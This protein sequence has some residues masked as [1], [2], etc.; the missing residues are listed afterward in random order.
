MPNFTRSLLTSTALTNVGLVSAGLIMMSGAAQ[1]LPQN[2]TVAG[3]SATISTSGNTTTINQS[4]SRAVIDWQ[5]FS[6]ASGETTNFVQPSSSSVA[7]NRVTGVNPS[8][9][10]GSL[11]ANGQV[12]LVNPNGILFNQGAQ[13]NV[14]GL[15]AS[16]ANISTANAMAGNMVFDQ[17]SASGTA[18]IVNKGTITAA[19]GGLVALV[20]PG[21]QNS[22]IITANLGK[23]SL[24]SGDQWT[25]D[26]YGDRLV[27]FT[28]NGQ[29]AA[30]ITGAKTD[31][32]G[33]P[34]VGVVQDKNGSI[35]ASA[36][37]VQITANVARQV[38]SNAI[39]MD[40]IVEASSV[41]TQG[42]AIV[43][44]AGDGNASITGTMNANGTQGGTI[45]VAA[46]TITNQGSLNANGTAGTGGTI[47]H[48]ATNEYIDTSLSSNSATGTEVGGTVNIAAGNQVFTSGNH[49]VSSSQG[50]GGSVNI[51]APTVNVVA[52]QINASGS[53]GGGQ[54]NIGPEVI[55]GNSTQAA[56][57]K[58]YVGPG[59]LLNANATQAGNGG[60]VDVVGTQTAT[61][62]GTATAEGGAQSGN[63]GTVLVAGQTSATYA[64]SVDTASANG[65]SGVGLII[66]T[67]N[68]ILGA[69]VGQLPQLTLID[70]NPNTGGEF[71]ATTATLSTGNV[72][73]TD[74]YDAVGDGP[75]NTGAVYLF[76]SQTGRLISVLMGSYNN[77]QVGNTVTVLTGNGNYVVSTPFWNGQRGAATWASGV[78]GVAGVV[79]ALNS[80]V[81]TNVDDDVS[82]GSSLT[83]GV[84]ALTNGNYVVSSPNWNNQ[85]G[86]ATL[87]NGATGTVGTV[88]ATNSLVGNVSGDE[89]GLYIS[90]LTN[91]NY[92][93]NSPFFTN[94]GAFDAGASTWANGASGIVGTI[95]TANSL[96]GSNTFDEIGQVPTTVLTNGNYVI[97]SPNWNGEYGAVTW[98]NGTTGITGTVDGTNSLIGSQTGDYVGSGGA[99]GGKG[100]VALT[101]GNYV[102]GT[103]TFNNNT[104][105]VTWGNG[106]GGTVGTISTANSLTGDQAGE[107]VG[108]TIIA[109]TNGNYVVQTP[110]WNNGTVTAAGAVTW[111]S[112]SGPTTGVVSSSNSLVGSNNY[113]EIG[114]VVVALANGNY[115]TSSANWNNDTG[116]VTW[117]NGTGGTTGTVSATNSFT[118]SVTGDSVGENLIALTNNNYVILSPF[119]N[120]STGA[121]TL[122]SGASPITGTVNAA[123]SL[124]GSTTGDLV[125]YNAYALADGNYVV[126]SQYWNGNLGA[127]T[128]GNGTT[129]IIGTI[130]AGNSLVGSTSGDMVGSNGVTALSDGDYI[131]LSSGFDG[132][133]G[134]ATLQYGGG[135]VT[136]TSFTG[137]GGTI[138]A[139][140]SVLGTVVQTPSTPGANLQLT[141]KEDVGSTNGFVTAFPTAGSGRVVIGYQAEPG[142]GPNNYGSHPYT[143]TGNVTADQGAIGATL[144]T[145]TNVTVQGSNDVTVANGIAL[146][147]AGQNANATLTLDAGRSILID[148]SIALAPSTTPG[149]INLNIVAN[150]TAA[151]GVIDSERLAGAAVITMANGTSITGGSG[152]VSYDLRTGAGNTNTTAGNVTLG[153]ISANQV[154]GVDENKGTLTLNGQISATAAAPNALVL[155]TGVFINNFGATALNTPNGE[156][157]VYST[158]PLT[159]SDNGIVDT[160]HYFGINYNQLPPNYNAA[161]S[162]FLYSIVPTLTLTPAGFTTVYGTAGVAP[163]P[164]Y[165][166]SGLIDGDTVQ[167]AATGINFTTGT[168]SASN[169]G[170]YT[171]AQSG[172]VGSPEGYV[173]V[174][175]TANEVITPAS[176]VITPN[177]ASRVYGASDPAYSASY[178]GLVL[179]QTSSVVSG[180]TLTSND[181]P[182]SGIG[183]YQITAGNGVAQNYAITYNNPG[184]LTVTP[185]TLTVTANPN[186]KTYGQNDPTLTY[187]DTGLVNGDTVSGSLARS[188]G[189]N[190]GTYAINQGTLTASTNYTVSFVG[191]SFTITPASLQVAATPVTT[192]YGTYPGLG[193][194]ATGLTNGDTSAVITGAETRT[195]GNNV[196]TYAIQQ[197]SLAASSNYTLT[198]T[199]ASYTITPATLSVA[200]APGSKVYGT[201]DGTLGYTA[202]GLTNG[203]T[204]SVVSGM[205][206]RAPGQNVGTYGINQGTLAAGSNYTISFTGNTFTITPATLTIAANPTT[207]VYGTYPGGTYTPS[208][209][210]NGDTASVISGALG[211]PSGVGVGTYSITQGTVGAGS[212]YTI[213]Y[214]GNS[215]VVTP[216]PLTVA[217]NPTTTVYGT[218]PAGTTGTPVGL[219]NG[220]T[221]SVVTGLV[222]TPTGVGVGTYAI[223]QGT[224][225]AGSNYTLTFVGNSYVIT[226]AP[227][228]VAANPVST[229]YG[230]YPAGTTQAPVGLVN[231]DTGSV[232]TGQVSTPSGVGVGTYMIGQGTLGVGPNYT[233]T[234][235]GNSY[236]ITPAPLTVMANPVNT[237]YGTYPAGTLM[238]PVGLVNGDTSS[239][240][241]GTPSTPS[242]VGI[243]TYTIG[244][245]TVG[246]TPN[247]TLTY[248]GNSY[249]ITPAPLTITTGPTTTTYGTTPTVPVTVTGL[250]NGDTSSTVTGTANV[251]PVTTGVGTY[252]IGQGTLTGSTNYTTS[253]VG[254]SVVINPAPLTITANDATR[255]LGTPDPTF[256]ATFSGLVNGESS[257]VVTGLTITSNDNPASLPGPY[258][259]TP[260]NGVAANYTITYVN[261]QLLVTPVDQP[262]GGPTGTITPVTP[263]TTTGT[264]NPDLSLAGLLASQ[265]Q[266]ATQVADTA[267]VTCIKINPDRRRTPSLQDLKRTDCEAPLQV[268]G[269]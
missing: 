214:V 171:I 247:Y 264:I 230:T 29:T 258:T 166:S 136:Q 248:V 51:S 130:T 117:G 235:V 33:Q 169:V 212:N 62:Y 35:T 246:T 13:V 50:T 4:S 153:A 194:T 61:F 26:M 204:S 149:V 111:A 176:L 200:A 135:A 226:P 37:Q 188:A 43:L 5:S 225:A 30:A 99:I 142:F 161:D 120:N 70:P 107:Q 58:V 266:G 139:Q 218:Y 81:G 90:P 98:A 180:L 86:A 198:F 57:T 148:G 88:D 119:W 185:A 269:F 175:G 102:V 8:T 177:S 151:S 196:G 39:N 241:T 127:A 100:V 233:L 209:L 36:G 34:L 259:I 173:I 183:T 95:S 242:G 27:S 165:S 18:V 201:A 73:V 244:Q 84:V 267:A 104:G 42:G 179:G 215:Y 236:V 76:N 205:L 78:N 38:V 133:L 44:D 145:G 160:H 128:L 197:G 249:V 227:L 206:A 87:G 48:T 93:V 12:V 184:I 158:S 156:Y 192:V 23:V 71:G 132:N 20:A 6:I 167:T 80:I 203:D 257:S 231:G 46:N 256:T 124:V 187:T 49:N 140:N 144:L 182:A 19:Q 52:A 21:V 245:G 10:A 143:T 114:S 199:G 170:T 68:P 53:T 55:T 172:A 41:S 210:T 174:E 202:S 108:F 82:V 106:N 110:F 105:A 40:G 193:Y 222:S 219:V 217:A 254:G 75:Y 1:A 11:N 54:I 129:G 83:P 220:D 255:P 123:N 15:V 17:S 115:A 191:N 154:L 65:T 195:A 137:N 85:V 211:T 189:Q 125:G 141:A 207:T 118:G 237:V 240:V 213:N 268:Q 77:D 97:A 60:T 122:A 126:T 7:V 250:T 47:T 14:G 243:G 66:N 178:Q 103:P 223:G 101:N 155:S 238:T 109:L 74:P 150:D 263:P 162:Y 32:N 121:A 63:G 16:T 79:S 181:T 262:P 31:F 251:P 164:V 152:N 94:G 159:N 45:T 67:Q 69:S 59:T 186:S 252:T 146:G 24:A 116:A 260:A 131:V 229:V 261:G 2:G 228:T 265:I 89:V 239:V 56:A 224:I 253:Y 72:V 91:G 112:G 92:V 157:I 138:T 28:V 163:S 64:G 9:I 234:Y 134:A 232:V 113:D 96:V 147:I 216:A 208:G 22:G 3:G 25:L 168:T 221:G 190:V